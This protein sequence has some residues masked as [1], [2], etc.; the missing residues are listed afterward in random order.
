MND[1]EIARRMRRGEKGA[2]LSPSTQFVKGHVPANKLP[3]GSKTVRIDQNGTKRRWIKVDEPNIWIRYPVYVW[4]SEGGEIPKGFILHHLDHDALND[5]IDNLCL[6]THSTHVELHRKEIQAGR[7]AHTSIK[8]KTCPDCGLVYE[9][10]GRL[11]AKCPN[12]TKEAQRR[13][14]REYK[15]R[16]KRERQD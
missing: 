3:V 7:K 8:Q 11:V 6:V 16:K 5:N 2:C 4:T 12:C 10:R 9:G 15:Q 1:S 14:K 13:Y